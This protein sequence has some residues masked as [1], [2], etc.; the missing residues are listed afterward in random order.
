MVSSTHI[1]LLTKPEYMSHKILFVFSASIDNCWLSLIF[2]SSV[3]KNLTAQFI[4]VKDNHHHLSGEQLLHQA[5]T[6]Q[7]S[8]H[9]P[10]NYGQDLRSKI[11][12]MYGNPLRL[13][14]SAAGCV[15]GRESAQQ[16]PL[17]NIS[18]LRH[19]HPSK[20]LLHE[21]E[22]WLLHQRWHLLQGTVLFGNFRVIRRPKQCI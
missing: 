15:F 19:F 1:S 2:N 8:T 20:G 5:T 6:I 17:W 14:P 3:E 13:L 16:I 4:I 21:T 11:L 7:I 10:F 12:P 18:F 22:N 9:C